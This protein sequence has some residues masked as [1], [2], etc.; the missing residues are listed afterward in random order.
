ML[1]SSS[2]YQLLQRMFAN[3]ANN[4]HGGVHLVF[5]ICTFSSEVGW[6]SL[7]GENPAREIRRRHRGRVFLRSWFWTD[8]LLPEELPNRQDSGHDTW[9]QSDKGPI[10]H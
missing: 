5:L 2:N 7:R 9:T 8:V 1:L 6:N 4:D 10:Q 3:D